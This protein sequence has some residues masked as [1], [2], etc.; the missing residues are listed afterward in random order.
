MHKPTMRTVSRWMVISLV[1]VVGASIALHSALVG[2]ADASSHLTAGT[3]L[4][5]RQ[6]PD[7]ALGDQ[8]GHTLRLSQLRGH[9]VVITFLDATCNTTCSVSAACLDQTGQLLAGSAGQVEW[10][11]V[12][13]NPSNTAADAQTFIQSHRITVPLRIL[14]GSPVQLSAVWQAYGIHVPASSAASTSTPMVSYVID[15]TGHERELLHP[16]YDP[17][18]AAQDIRALS[19]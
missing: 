8:S 6:A 15:A 7:F 10:L 18:A 9:V 16:A 12:S 11:A 13:I 19:A 14:L 5:G 1:V 4:D 3:A 17:K 2:P